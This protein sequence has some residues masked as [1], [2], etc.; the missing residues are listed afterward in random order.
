M[1]HANNFKDI[2]GQR[3]GYLTAIRPV[4]VKET[5]NKKANR[6]MKR[7]VWLFKCDCGKEVEKCR[8]TLERYKQIG[9]TISC[10]CKSFIEKLGNKHGLWKG[11]GEISSTYFTYLKRRS[12]T[13]GHRKKDL[14]FDL[15]IE[16]LW[17]LF[18][19]QN[20]K[21]VFSGEILT[22]GT[23]AQVRNK[24]DREPSASLDRI[25]SSKG[26]VEGN[27]QWVHKNLNIM[28]QD[29]TDDVFVEWCK[30]VASYRSVVELKL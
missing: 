13:G 12:K 26:Y 21:C 9:L 18:L 15:S 17:D 14:T 25:D 4:G 16:Y 11:Y 24:K 27:V 28:K 30:K 1:E 6:L 22:F 20:R 19:K 7:A 29:L 8:T 5:F 2:T 23:L 3:Y 10:G